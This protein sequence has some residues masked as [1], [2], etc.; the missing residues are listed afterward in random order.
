M[1]STIN[2]AVTGVG[3]R[4]G[5]R[6]VQ[7]I[8]T[9]ADLKLVDALVRP[10][11]PLIGRD[12]GEISGVGAIGVSCAAEIDFSPIPHVLI[13][14]STPGSMRHWL[15]VCAHRRIP[16]IVGTT[17]LHADD[18]RAID[19]AS[20]ETPVLQAANT[21][22]GVAVLAR[23][24]AI[25]A[26]SLGSGFDI[27]IVETHHRQKRDAPSGT[28]RLLADRIAEVTGGPIVAGRGQSL[29]LR[30]PGEITIHAMRVGAVVGEHE[31]HFAG[32]AERIRL[33]HHA[34]DRSV[35]AAGAL[36][37]ARWLAGRGAGRYRMEDVL[38][39]D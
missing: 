33:A 37:A 15:A 16:M 4:M 3:G 19:E 30:T 36:T 29:S 26:K 32:S 6:I 31:V 39:V 10:D 5:N 11:S 1:T 13:D 27:E 18:H 35:F 2:I 23:L 25:A 14:F 28:A 24:C 21:S 17:G 7:H 9:S 8:A 20:L 22:V 34:E 38:G 12:A